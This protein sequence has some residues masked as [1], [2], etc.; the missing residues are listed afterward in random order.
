MQNFVSS[1]LE[2]LVLLTHT[3]IFQCFRFNFI[4]AV[5]QIAKAKLHHFVCNVTYLHIISH[6]SI[7]SD[8]I[9]VWEHSVDRDQMHHKP[10]YINMY[11]KI[12]S[13]EQY[14]FD[15][16]ILHTKKCYY[17]NNVGLWLIK[18]YECKMLLYIK[19][20][21]ICMFYVHILKKSEWNCSWIAMREASIYQM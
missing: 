9:Y 20:L 21:L 17:G 14:L 11:L 15:L 18:I 13:D 19:K 1:F 8:V 2:I 10:L 3:H 6:K 12:S 4:H 16:I 7:L 5:M